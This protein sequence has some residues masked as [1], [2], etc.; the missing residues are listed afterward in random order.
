M[1]QFLNRSFLPK[2]NDRMF[3]PRSAPVALAPRAGVRRVAFA[4]AE[5][6]ALVL[7]GFGNT[8]R[9]DFVI[10]QGFAIRSNIRIIYIFV[11]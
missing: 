6:G 3:T 11:I 9:A 8:A 2:A 10:R 7:G 4:T 5:V 1:N